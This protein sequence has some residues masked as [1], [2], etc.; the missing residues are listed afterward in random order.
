MKPDQ[1]HKMVAEA[2]E[3][4]GESL[5]A[6]QSDSLKNFLRA[7]ARF[8]AYSV[9]NAMLIAMQ[10]P[11][12]T[13]V[14]GYNTWK[15]L[16]RQVRHGAKG[17]SI[18]APV[19]ARAPKAVREEHDVEAEEREPEATVVSF[20]GATV[21]DLADT[22][23]RPLPEFAKARG[24]PGVYLER[25]QE[26]IQQQDIAIEYAES[27][28]GAEGVSRGKRIMVRQDLPPAE[29]F[30]VLVH[31]LGHEMLHRGE[32]S[33]ESRTVRETEAEATAYVVC[34][35]IGVDS[36]QTSADYV[37]L[38]DGNVETLRQSLHRIRRTAHRIIDAI[39]KDDMVRAGMVKEVEV[40]QI[41][42][43]A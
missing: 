30:S 16:G 14:A 15:A 35:A 9:G 29:M 5:A 43:A 20:R 18:V 23:G 28:G 13:R 40:E 39:L 22:D 3:R 21:F 8:H 19:V 31:E 34:E 26:Y 7:M 6:G 38:Y 42:E 10:R 1:A 12:A 17:I 37:L 4:L 32:D 41:A 11:D 25:L 2:A 36:R 27:L 24:A 33:P